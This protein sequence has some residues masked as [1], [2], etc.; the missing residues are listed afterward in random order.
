MVDGNRTV[1][2]LSINYENQGQGHHAF[3]LGCRAGV[4]LARTAFFS[5]F[6]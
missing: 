3:W 1:N 6:G 2:R 5:Y 4:K